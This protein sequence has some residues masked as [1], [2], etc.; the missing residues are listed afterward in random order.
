MRSMLT[1]AGALLSGR[2]P[3]C[4][5]AVLVVFALP[6]TL[7]GQSRQ[8]DTHNSRLVIRVLKAG[9]FSAFGD[10]H[11]VEAPI[12]EGLV[13]EQTRRVALVIESQHLKVLDPQLSSEKRQQVQERM[14]GPEVLNVAHFPRITFES[15][16]IE[17]TG[18]GRLIVHGQLS[19]H[20][21]TH[22]VVVNAWTEGEHYMGT[23]TFK[24]R[25]FGITPV[26]I[27]GGTVKVKDELTIEFDIR[28]AAATAG[29]RSR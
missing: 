18:S 15:T 7:V 8:I 9:L 13:D 19:L 26:S 2:R 12:S 28:T 3:C 16:S 25:Q 10:N 29:V 22:P 27:A 11:E 17:P 14:L 6:Q 21:E 4:A 23:C 24:Q 5:L 1:N 20:G